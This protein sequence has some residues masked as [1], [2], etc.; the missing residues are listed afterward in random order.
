MT[1]ERGRTHQHEE[2]LHTSIALIGLTGSRAWPAPRLLEDTLLHIWHDA[3]QDGCNGVELMHGCADGPQSRWRRGDPAARSSIQAPRVRTTA[4]SSPPARDI[5]CSNRPSCP[6]L[7]Q[8]DDAGRHGDHFGREDLTQ[9]ADLVAERHRGEPCLVHGPG[10]PPLLDQEAQLGRGRVLQ[11]S[12]VVQ[13]AVQV[14]VVPTV[15]ER[16]PEDLGHVRGPAFPRHGHR[17][18]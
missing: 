4:A 16:L 8:T 10:T 1:S 18:T 3:L 14:H 5:V 13:M 15:F 2:D 7:A 17:P 11:V 9:M 6:V 12:R